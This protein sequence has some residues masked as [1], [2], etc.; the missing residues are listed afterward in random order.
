MSQVPIATSDA[1]EVRD[2]VVDDADARFLTE[3]LLG[4]SRTF[5]LTIPRLPEP[6]RWVV[7]DAYLLCRIAD[8]IEDEPALDVE[9]KNRFHDWFRQVVMGRRPPRP[10]V[11]ELLPRL[12]QRTTAAERRLVAEVP[13]V[14]EFAQRLPAQARQAIDRTLEIMCAGM[15]RFQRHVSLEGLRD[16]SELNHYCYYVAGVVGEMLTDLF[17]IYDHA[18]ERVRS[19]LNPLSVSFGQ[20]LQ[21]TNILKDFW[22][23]R[24]HGVCWFP[25]DVFA[26]YGASL[27]TLEPREGFNAGMKDLIAITHRNLRQ[28]L[29][30][31]LIIPHEARGIREFCLWAIGYAVFTLRK[32]IKHLDYSSGDEVKISRRSV[33]L[34]SRT[35]STCAPNDTLLR[36]LF[37]LAARPLPLASEVTADTT[38]SASLSLPP[39]QD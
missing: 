36:M 37:T 13:R 29:T 28:A 16:L 26:R 33:R 31:T 11:D 9:D 2:V 15:P 6:L 21:M 3:M 22:E 8:T 4:T 38:G 7:S 20:G 34:I 5:A 24:Q 1:R 17:C 35:L 10:F 12:S 30:Y 19:R 25:Q 14:V 39:T 18:V 23:D 27:L 32:L